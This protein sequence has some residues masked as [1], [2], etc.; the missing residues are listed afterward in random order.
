MLEAITQAGYKP[1]EQ[2]GVCLDPAASEF[3]QDGKYVF[4]KSDKSQRSPSRWWNIWANWVRQYPAILSL[5][6]GMSEEDWAGMETAD[7][8]AR[9]ENPAGWRRHFRHQPRDLPARHRR[10]ESPTRF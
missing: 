2:I 7:R 5:E 9:Q 1:G 3:Y 6:D 4:K 8:H 10:R